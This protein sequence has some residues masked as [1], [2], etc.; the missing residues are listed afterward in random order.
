MRLLICAECGGTGTVLR[1]VLAARLEGVAVEMTGCLGV[2]ADP[3]TL[4]AQAD[5]RATYVFSGLGAGDAAE[6]A[7]FVAAYRAAPAGW[8]EDARPLGR[9]R[10]CMVTRVPA[11]TEAPPDRP[12]R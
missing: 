6:V 11:L 4:A 10:H 8:I 2:C 3:V 7:A 12:S 5:G 1:E 9:L